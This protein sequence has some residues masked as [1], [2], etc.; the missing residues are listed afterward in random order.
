MSNGNGNLM[1]EFEEA[2][3]VSVHCGERILDILNSR[4]IFI[5]SIFQHCL[6]VLTKQEPQTYDDDVIKLEVEQTTMNFINLA[7]QIEVFFLQKRFLLATLKPELLLMEENYDLKHELARK[8][9][10][11]KKHS[12]KIEQWK[13]LLS[14]QPAKPIV[15]PNV[16]SLGVLP[17]GSGVNHPTMVGPGLQVSGTLL[18]NEQLLIYSNY[19]PLPSRVRCTYNKCRCNSSSSR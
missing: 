7:R 10:L 3:Q 5:F 15:P 6:H 11:I 13:K 17:P 14:D 12:E 2:F 1:D 16:P 9:E 4:P 19:S 8:E 18:D